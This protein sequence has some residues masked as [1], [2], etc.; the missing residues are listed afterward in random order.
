[1]VLRNTPC[2]RAVRTVHLVHY[3]GMIC[4][5]ALCY[6][7]RSTVI[8]GG[9]NNLRLSLGQ[10]LL[11]TYHLYTIEAARYLISS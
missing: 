2:V 11:L 6:N 1:M 10:I 4:P 5:L 7:C 3:E 9:N 8:D